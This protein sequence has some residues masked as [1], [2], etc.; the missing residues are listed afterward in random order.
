MAA[1]PRL[2]L[3]QSAA[4]TLTPQM[5]QAIALLQMSNLELGA[6]VAEQIE[7]NPLLDLAETRGAAGAGAPRG[8][9]AVAPIGRFGGDAPAVVSETVSLHDH[10][11]RQLG[12]VAGDATEAMIGDFLI[13]ILYDAGYLRTTAADAAAELGCAPDRVAAGLDRLQRF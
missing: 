3:R 10:L 4:L 7:R 13:G 12:A 6:A 5:R 2:Q 9:A 8:A 1:G 11:R